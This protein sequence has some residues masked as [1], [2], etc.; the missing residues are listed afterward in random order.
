MNPKRSKMTRACR[1]MLS[2]ACRSA[3]ETPHQKQMRDF[4]SYTLARPHRGQ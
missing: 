4:Q 3:S 2:I 1:S